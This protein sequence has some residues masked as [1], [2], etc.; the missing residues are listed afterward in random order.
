MKQVLTKIF[1]RYLVLII[2]VLGLPIIFWITWVQSVGFTYVELFDFL[3]VLIIS[4][5]LGIIVVRYVRNKQHGRLK[6]LKN[7]M[8]SDSICFILCVIIAYMAYMIAYYY[9]GLFGMSFCMG[10]IWYYLYWEWSE[11]KQA[12]K[13]AE[14]QEK[15]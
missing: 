10:N 8:I 13:P 9:M 1:G 7:M 4:V 12:Q 5:F 6:D 3:M 14:A 15:K 2:A 11:K